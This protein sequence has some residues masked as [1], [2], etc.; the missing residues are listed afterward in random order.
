[1]GRRPQ[2]DFLRAECEISA[3][4]YE[5]SLI[6]C[7]SRYHYRN[8]HYIV[9]NYLKENPGL[10]FLNWWPDT[11]YFDPSG[12]QSLE[13]TYINEDAVEVKTSFT[14]TQ[15]QNLLGIFSLPHIHEQLSG[16][17][18]GVYLP[19]LLRECT[20]ESDIIYQRCLLSQH[21]PSIRA[22]KPKS[23]SHKL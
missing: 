7:V 9:K 2:L 8:S 11:E 18:I 5:F 3:T 16:G 1:V 12:L 15:F 17:A 13:L 21:C 23:N 10:R 22:D 4:L 6:H 14:D 19:Q 20:L